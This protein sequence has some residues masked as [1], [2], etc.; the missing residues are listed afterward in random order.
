MAVPGSPFM[1]SE[2]CGTPN[3]MDLDPFHNLLFYSAIGFTFGTDNIMAFKIQPDGSIASSGFTFVVYNPA[4]VTLDP[5]YQYMYTTEVDGY[6]GKPEIV[7]IKYSGTDGSGT[8]Y[9]GPLT[10]PSAKAIQIAVSR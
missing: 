4:A 8:I 10:R 7:S 1:V 2:C 9:S 6:T 5:S 3:M